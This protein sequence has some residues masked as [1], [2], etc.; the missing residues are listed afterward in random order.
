MSERSEANG[1]LDYMNNPPDG[2]VD[3]PGDADV[4]NGDEGV[5]ADGRLYTQLGHGGWDADAD[6]GN[7]HNAG[8]GHSGNI[9]VKTTTSCPLPRFARPPRSS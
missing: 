6:T 1:F 3:L 8:V 7:G 4:T 9:T 5:W 2:L